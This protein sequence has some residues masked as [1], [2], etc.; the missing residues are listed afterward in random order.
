MFDR[1]VTLMEYIEG[2]NNYEPHEAKVVLYSDGIRVSTAC[3]NEYGRRFS[4][5]D[6]QFI[7]IVKLGNNLWRNI[8]R[9]Y[10][11]D[12]F[13]VSGYGYMPLFSRYYPTIKD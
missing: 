13:V 1:I 5:E 12:Y 10:A 7:P 3:V 6:G 9:K 2:Q 4:N 11:K 8:R